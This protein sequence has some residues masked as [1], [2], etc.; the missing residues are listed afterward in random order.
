MYADIYSI[1]L[2]SKF[3]G[4]M[5]THEGTSCCICLTAP[6]F[7]SPL[8]SGDINFNSNC[9]C[10]YKVHD[11]CMRTWIDHAKYDDTIYHI[12]NVPKCII[13]NSQATL[14]HDYRI[15]VYKEAMPYYYIRVAVII[16]YYI[17]L[18]SWL[19]W[20]YFMF[21]TYILSCI[22]YGILYRIILLIIM[23]YM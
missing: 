3:E 21:S 1:L 7:M 23:G 4:I 20:V 9:E 16:I 15:R 10:L 12:S 14:S 2:V 17:V 13:C 22:Y 11:V 6:T 18:C 5:Y 8:V 19:F